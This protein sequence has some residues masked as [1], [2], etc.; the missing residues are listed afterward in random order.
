MAAPSPEPAPPPPPE[1]LAPT[2]VVTPTLAVPTPAEETPPPPAPKEEDA[3]KSPMSMNVWGRVGGNIHNYSDPKKLNRFSQNA[4]VDLLMNMEI[5]KYFGMTA[6]FVGTYGPTGPGKGDITGSIGIMDLIAKLELD[7]AFHLWVGRMLV[8]TDR[9]NFSGPW[10][11]APWNYPTFFVPFAPPVGPREGPSGRNDGATVWGQFKGGMLKYYLGAYDMF[12]DG[13]PLISGRINLALIAPEPGYYSSSTYYG[14]K[15][16][17][18]LAVGGQYQKGAA[19]GFNYGMFNADLL[20]EK[21]TGVGTFDVEGA[22]YKYTASEDPNDW[23]Y[24]A[25]ASWLTPGKVGIGALQ[26]LVRLQQNKTSDAMGPASTWT[27]VDAQLGYVID[28]Y[29]CRLALGYQ[30]SNVMG[31]KGNNIFMGIQMQK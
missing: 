11:I 12:K 8:A 3:R 13:N 2:P 26:P 10:F 20:F 31:T 30:Y 22:F 5:I 9:S 19:G 29:A 15:D 16:V 18:S 6:N 17:L 23:T 24:F 7:D 4:E 28:S 21:K 1:V 25:L 14:A 27:L